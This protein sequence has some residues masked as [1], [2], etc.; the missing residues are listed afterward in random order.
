MP[1]LSLSLDQMKEFD[2]NQ[3][4][5]IDVR[6][7]TAYNHGFIPGAI[8]VDL[9]KILEGEYLPP[10]DKKIILY[11]LKGIISEE[12]AEYL[13]QKG[14][15][16][17]NLEGGYGKWLISSMEKEKEEDSA[18]R[19]DEIERSLRK[20]FHKNIFSRFAKAINEYQLVKEHDKIAVCISGGKDSMLM[21]KLFQE[22]RRHNKFPF[23][24]VFLV[25]DPGYNGMNREVIE[26]NAKLLNIPITVFETQIFDAVYD[27]EKSPCYLCARMRRGY[28]YSKAKELGCN[29]IALGHHYDDVIETILMGMM[30]GGQIQTMMPKLHSTNFEGMELIR[31]MYLI[32]EDD[33]KAW[34]D[35]NGLHFIQCACRFTDTCTTCRTDGNTGSKRVEIKE[36]IKEL[37]KVNPYIE[38]NIFKSVENVNLNTIIAYKEDG[39]VHHFLD[40]YDENR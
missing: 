17:Y 27:V 14:F 34:R 40:E 4:L 39:T 21:A 32:R 31:P 7:Q 35:Y 18:V 26:S 30:Y 38:G 3:C 33:I 29:K 16:A 6:D 15:E 8:Q 11:C 20:K 37:K 10:A 25:M 28:L 23:E 13:T 22:I 2:E 5:L 1:D 12:A 24:L 36:L 9:E 19:L